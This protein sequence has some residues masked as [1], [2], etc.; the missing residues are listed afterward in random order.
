MNSNQRN[1]QSGRQGDGFSILAKRLKGKGLLLY[2]ES[3]S[4]CFLKP[5]LSTPIPPTVSTTG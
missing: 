2:P 5:Y 1:L 4:F 3:C